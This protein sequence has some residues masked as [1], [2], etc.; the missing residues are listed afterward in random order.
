MKPI[1]LGFLAL[2][3]AGL[4]RA[5]TSAPARLFGRIESESGG[6]ARFAQVR[7]EGAALVGRENSQVIQRAGN[8]GS[9]QISLPAGAYEIW[10][11][12]PDLPAG[13]GI[14]DLGDRARPRGVDFP[15]GGRIRGH[16]EPGRTPLGTAANPVPG[17]D[18]GSP[19][20]DD[21]RSFGRGVHAP[22]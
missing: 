6:P 14:R 12:A 3:S 16:R 18:C 17:R 5:A 7:V 9:F 15:T 10:V 2:I 4:A 1:L 11:T 22:G 19:A 8:D 20:D 21:P 13:W